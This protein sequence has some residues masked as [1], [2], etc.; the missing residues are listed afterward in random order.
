MLARVCVAV[1]EGFLLVA[2]VFVLAQ[3][4]FPAASPSPCPS[5]P[6][7]ATPAPCGPKEIGRVVSV[8]RKANLVGKAQAASAGTIDQAQIAARPVL[9]PGEVLEA[10]PGLVISQHSGEG[11]ANQYYLRGFQLDHG[12]DL[13]STIVGVPIN[14]PSHAHGQGYSDINWVIPELVS[15]VEFKKGPYFA[16]QGDFSTAG[17]Y[18]LYYK[19]SIEPTME[20]GGGSYGYDRYFAAASP[21]VGAGT[22]TYGIE[23]LHD[24][25]SFDK[26]DE[27][28][29][30]N[31]VLRYALT[32]GSNE[33]TVTGM[34]YSGPFNSTDQIPQRLVDEG[35]IDRFG[36]IDPSDGGN[37]YRYALSAQ[38][39]HQDPN[40]VTKFNAYGVDY[41]LDLFSN[42]TYYQFDGND[43]FNETANSVTCNPAFATCNPYGPAHHTSDYSSYC[44]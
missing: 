20:V 26:P 15:Y 36:Y 8:G 12:T 19:T 43:Y 37:T 14:M 4:A 39:Q 28:H 9:R 27:Y 7:S 34:A 40:G 2:L 30:Y 35:V 33:F 42:F 5:S 6:P 44:P 29:K 38:W 31:G 18:N 21:R 41:F 24:N 3:A 25:G 11:K 10:I 32:K 16:D 22:L 23:L 13:E 17:A 1:T